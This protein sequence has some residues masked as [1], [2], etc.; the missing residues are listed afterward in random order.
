MK[1]SDPWL[2]PPYVEM[3]AYIFVV[4]MAHTMTVR[5]SSYQSTRQHKQKK[6]IQTSQNIMQTNKQ[7]HAKDKGV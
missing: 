2:L 3:G 5:V 7:H 6:I 1:T 4:L